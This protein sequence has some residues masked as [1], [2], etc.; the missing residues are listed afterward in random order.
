LNVSTERLT[1]LAVTVASIQISYEGKTILDFVESYL[2][3]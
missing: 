3:G 2:E 1:L